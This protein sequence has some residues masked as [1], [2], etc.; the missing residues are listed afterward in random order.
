METITIKRTQLNI[1]PRTAFD[2][3]SAQELAKRESAQE[4]PASLF[5]YIVHCS[6]KRNLDHL[7]W[8]RF[9]RRLRISRLVSIQSLVRALSIQEMNH[10]ITLINEAEKIETEANNG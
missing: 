5:T 10:I 7:P 8:Y 6:L 2:V 3:L 1:Y 4:W 9:L